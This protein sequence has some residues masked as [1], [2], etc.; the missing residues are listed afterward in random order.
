MKVEEKHR[1]ISRKRGKRRRKGKDIASKRMRKKEECINKSSK[2]EEV[3]GKCL[4]ADSEG[5]WGG[6]RRG[7]VRGCPGAP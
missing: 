5:C 2:M 3:Q 1:T 7:R 6:E 4:D